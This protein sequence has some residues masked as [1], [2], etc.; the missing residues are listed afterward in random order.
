MGL[1]SNS[2]GHYPD[3]ARTACVHPTAVLVG[4]VIVEEG[5]LIGPQAVVR[6]DEPGP[7]GTVKPIL[8][9]REAN[10]QDGV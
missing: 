6:A 7:D 1:E 8:I 4:R 9:G 2:L 3:I 10:I 5:V